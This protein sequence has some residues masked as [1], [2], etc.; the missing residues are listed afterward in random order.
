[1]SL[2]PTEDP[3]GDGLQFPP[4]ELTRSEDTN[5]E[6]T[7]EALQPESGST[8]ILNRTAQFE[9][10]Q[11]TEQIASIDFKEF[12]DL[13]LNNPKLVRPIGQYVADAFDYFGSREES[14]AG[15]SIKVFEAMNFPWRGKLDAQ[16]DALLG[17]EEA[18]FDFYQ[19][20]LEAA[21]GSHPTRLLLVHGPKGSGKTTFFKML[22]EMLEEYSRTDQGK[23]F[24]LSFE[25]PD[26]KGTP[27]GFT[28][29]AEES[30]AGK[31]TNFRIAA[32]YDV[33]PFTVL[34]NPSAFSALK[35]SP[36]E[37]Q[38][39]V[40]TPRQLF[41]DRLQI[42]NPDS[43]IC[44]PYILE[45]KPDLLTSR[46]L[47]RLERYYNGDW[48]KV[49]SHVR[50]E[51]FTIS[52]ERQSGIVSWAPSLS[53][54]Y[55]GD[56]LL[57]QPGPFDPRKI[58]A[59]L[60]MDADEIRKIR[61]P[62]TGQLIVH[63]PNFLIPGQSQQ[64]SLSDYT[65]LLSVENGYIQV[66]TSQGLADVPSRALFTA[67][68]NDVNLLNQMTHPNYPHF[69]DRAELITF[70]LI[71][72]FKSE[73]EVYQLAARKLTT[74][75]NRPDP[76][77]L[78]TLAL[79]AVATRLL[80]PDSS[81]SEYSD[82]VRPLIPELTEIEKAILL[83]ERVD[84]EIINM[85]RD[86]ENRLDDQELARLRA[87]V[88][89]FKREHRLGVGETRLGLYDG[90][91]GISTR[92]GKELLLRGIIKD[93]GESPITVLDVIDFLRE[94]QKGGYRY[95][96]YINR[97]KEFHRKRIR[98][99]FLAKD[100]THHSDR[101]LLEQKVE[102]RFNRE[103]PH[104]PR[105][106]GEII[107]QLED[108]A[109]KIVR[110]DIKNAIGVVEKLEAHKM[111][112]RYV[113]NLI[114]YNNRNNMSL[115]VEKPET[116][117]TGDRGPDEHFLRHYEDTYLNW[118]SHEIPEK[119]A[120]LI[121]QARAEKKSYR[122]LR[123]KEH[124][125]DIM[126]QELGSTLSAKWQD[127]DKSATLVDMAVSFLPTHVTRIERVEAQRRRNI[128]PEFM[129]DAKQFGGPDGNR[130][131][132]LAYQGTADERARVERWERACRT[133]T[134]KMGYSKENLVKTI[135]WALDQRASRTARRRTHPR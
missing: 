81:F 64:G 8:E 88:G 50:A 120:Q 106:V 42:N 79:F 126:R 90:G 133:M 71:T 110:A 29:S 85:L 104:L 95:E 122:H 32:G 131:I 124:I 11:Y 57:F 63:L 84:V 17:Q 125:R 34:S 86:E 10:E 107:D 3:M 31:G 48:E 22:H 112:R 15:R 77:T 68:V 134:E 59:E 36:T 23:L 60:S 135:V 25:F 102:E 54:Q 69:M 67:D 13:A 113:R 70:G 119:Q 53:G 87:E 24:R 73:E 94:R 20:C 111:V 58:P 65:F 7:A 55:P 38:G 51:P 100:P 5:S 128:L 1:M 40:A 98:D 26:N 30:K 61:D 121:Q 74:E 92:G 14:I 41:L 89:A 82:N 99:E 96:E 33:S 83:E 75:K 52:R 44:A 118:D 35:Q 93:A 80:L 127:S 27:L 21:K 108:Y 115:T 129:E 130:I 4:R 76:H 114:A 18:I 45:A 72:R 66:N 132:E 2:R 37:E 6:Q 116:S 117:M 46:I 47:E 43:K 28:T 49:L 19:A 103:F 105:S 12:L 39:E 56:Q 109:R 16:M 91:F 78:E 101:S 97:V 123:N 62:R 9:L